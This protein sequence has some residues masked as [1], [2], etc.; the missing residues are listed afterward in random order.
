MASVRKKDWISQNILES[1]RYFTRFLNRS[2]ALPTY[3]IAIYYKYPPPPYPGAVDTWITSRGRH[4]RRVTRRIS[5]VSTVG[6]WYC[7]FEGWWC[8]AEG[9]SYRFCASA[10]ALEKGWINYS[11]GDKEERRNLGVNW[12]WRKKLGVIW[13][14]YLYPTFE[15]KC[16]AISTHDIPPLHEI[17]PWSSSDWCSYCFY[18]DPWKPWK[19]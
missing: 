2:E 15:S 8:G 13:R 12:I 9:G 16:W 10:H 4:R 19:Y 18:P 11:G 3:H 17:H 6:P 7:V 5:A 1:Y 14:E